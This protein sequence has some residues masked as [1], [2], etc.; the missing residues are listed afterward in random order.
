MPACD[1]AE[2]GRAAGHELPGR[3]R[4]LV[5][6]APDRSRGG[7]VRRH[8]SGGSSMP[9]GTKACVT[10]TVAAGP[11]LVVADRGTT[12]HTFREH[13]RNLGSR[14][15]TPLQRHE[16]PVAGS[17]ISAISSGDCGP[18]SRS[19]APS[20]PATFERQRG[21]TTPTSFMGVRCLAFTST[22][23]RADGPRWRSRACNRYGLS[24]Y[25]DL[26]RSGRVR[27]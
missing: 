11:R 15:V 26:A 10:P 24:C 22:G 13:V 7:L 5:G 14:P 21:S 12:S 8:L 6:G 18:S 2:T 23:S 25:A 9:D 1:G 3:H 16:T 20:R 27:I 17:A 4:R 19:G